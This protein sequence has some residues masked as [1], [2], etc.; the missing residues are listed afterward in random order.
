TLGPADKALTRPCGRP[1]QLQNAR[2]KLRP[3]G[4]AR[5]CTSRVSI[6]GACTYGAGSGKGMS[7][8]FL[9]EAILSSSKPFK[10]SYK[11][12]YGGMQ[13]MNR[14]GFTLIALVIV[15]LII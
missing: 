6:K 3:R 5:R 1:G 15:V 11:A 9:F 10:R 8:A 12:T 7:L 2:A 13:H 4:V 14:T